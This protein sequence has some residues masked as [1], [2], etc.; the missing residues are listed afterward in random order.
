MQI[1]QERAEP[2]GLQ[3]HGIGRSRV[4]AR[5]RL[6]QSQKLLERRAQRL[7]V[8]GDVHRF[9][10]RECRIGNVTQRGVAST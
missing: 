10:Q 3:G 7:K 5:N 8:S 6:G 9:R 1:S 4:V 2:I